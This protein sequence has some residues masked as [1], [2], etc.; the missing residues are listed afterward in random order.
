M[1]RG[2]PVVHRAVLLLLF[3]AIRATPM[4]GV[5]PPVPALL[6]VR[7]QT[8][9]QLVA[10]GRANAS[11][12]DRLNITVATGKRHLSTIFAKLEVSNRSEAVAAA[13]GRKIL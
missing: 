1:A 10:A 2:E 8:V 13:R 4:A 12:A 11:I 7:E 3:N 9:L 5:P 6:T